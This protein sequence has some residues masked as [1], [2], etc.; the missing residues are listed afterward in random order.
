VWPQ[1]EVVVDHRHLSVEQEA[2]VGGVGLETGEQFV[3][4]VDEP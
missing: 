1:L 2:G 3:E 4:D